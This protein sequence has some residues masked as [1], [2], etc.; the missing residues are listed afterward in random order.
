MFINGFK[1]N[2]DRIKV[3]L[4]FILKNAFENN[5]IIDNTPVKISALNH[6]FRIKNPDK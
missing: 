2:K 3:I 1:T 4:W 6:E 5:Q